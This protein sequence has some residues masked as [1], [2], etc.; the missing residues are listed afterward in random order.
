MYTKSNPIVRTAHIVDDMDTTRTLCDKLVAPRWLKFE[1]LTDHDGMICVEC[2]DEQAS[3]KADDE[4]DGGIDHVALHE[5]MT[6]EEAIAH[7]DPTEEEL[8]EM[9][10]ALA[11][12]EKNLEGIIDSD[13]AQ[14]NAYADKYRRHID[15]EGNVVTDEEDEFDSPEQVRIRNEAH[16]EREEAEAEEYYDNLA[17][18]D[19]DEATVA[20]EEEAV[21]RAIQTTRDNIDDLAILTIDHTPSLQSLREKA[22]AFEVLF[23]REPV[24]Y[25]RGQW[26]Q[27]WN[28]V[29]S[30]FV[31]TPLSGLLL[32]L[33]IKNSW[34][35]VVDQGD[36]TE[37]DLS[38]SG[39]TTVYF[40]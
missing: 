23:D 35:R 9:D 16:Q 2:L 21:D 8:Q 36:P 1:N 14:M 12:A 18:L 13:D 3:R 29:K 10:N 22:R 28:V 27:R 11:A 38:Q 20:T 34:V 32:V 5:G 24:V 39:I 6:E 30:S 33:K 31:T 19:V 17:R 26:H 37:W 25:V 4:S 7:G 15:Y 40:L